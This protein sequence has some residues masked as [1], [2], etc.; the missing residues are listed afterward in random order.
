M[1]DFETILAHAESVLAHS[2]TVLTPVRTV[3]THYIIK[4]KLDVDSVDLPE[5][6]RV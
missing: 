5:A 6:I 2:G 1:A 3:L 4:K